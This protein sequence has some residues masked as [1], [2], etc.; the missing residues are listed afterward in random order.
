MRKCILLLALLSPLLS[1]CVAAALGI[2]A[3][4]VISQEV[5]DNNSYVVQLNQDVEQVWLVTKRTLAE[6]STEIIE[7]DED[8]RVAKGDWD[9]ATI[10]ASVEAYDLDQSFLKVSAT[11]YGVSNGELAA[12]FKDKVVRNLA[13]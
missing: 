6:T 5:L 13:E 2:G 12:L 1:G 8:L 3:G 4:L 9:G 7:V 10:T 11:R